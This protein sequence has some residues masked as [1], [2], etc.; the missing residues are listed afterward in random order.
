MVVCEWCMDVVE[1]D[2]AIEVQSSVFICLDCYEQHSELHQTEQVSDE[3][4]HHATT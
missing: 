3:T 2:T 1:M 4:G